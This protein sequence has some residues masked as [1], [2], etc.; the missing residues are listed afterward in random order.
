M[1]EPV[2]RI[3][4]ELQDIQPTIWRRVDVPLSCTLMMLND[5]IQV[6]MGWQDTHLFDFRIGDRAY[7]V[8]SDEMDGPRV[9]SAK[10][11]RLRDVVA[12]GVERF[13]YV[14]DFGD[15]W[16]HD[17]TIEAVRDGEP[18]ID[19]PVFV[20]GAGRGP[21]EDVGGP[22]GFMAFLEA[23]LNP[24][25]PEH[26]RMLEWYGGPFRPDDIDEAQIRRILGW[27]AYRRRGPLASQRDRR[28]RTR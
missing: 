12:R 4:I 14:Y 27:I 17:V 9:F 24:V 16:R 7:G 19:Y 2:A 28:G 15:D 8:P 20:G 22:Y 25:H 26:R 18:D 1:I 13:L 3:R 10:S 23:A 6:A 5:I 21:P 11:L